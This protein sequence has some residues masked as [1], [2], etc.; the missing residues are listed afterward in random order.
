MG[1]LILLNDNGTSTTVLDTGNSTI[2]VT[3]TASDIVANNAHRIATDDPHDVQANQV[4]YDNSNTTLEA[5]SNAVTSQTALTFLDA[6]VKLNTAKE[7][8]VTTDLSVSVSDTE[9]TV[10]S[11]DGTNATLVTASDTDAGI[12]TKDMFVKLDGIEA[13]ADVT[14]T[15]NVDA[16][17]AVMN[18]DTTIVSMDFVID[19]DDMSSN[20][21]TKVPTQQSVKSYTDN[22]SIVMAMIF[23]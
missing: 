7:T 15:D 5:T 13:L 3:I 4:T 21:D 17:G 22:T 9:V 1:K 16:A 10:E 18:T 19:E 2:D 20:I 11:S 23:G 8:N 12:C 6:A 14:D